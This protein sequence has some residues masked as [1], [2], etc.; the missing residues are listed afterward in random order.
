MRRLLKQIQDLQDQVNSL[1]EKEFHH[2]D[3]A[4]SS[5]VSH[6]PSQPVVVPSSREVL[7]RDSGL[8]S[9]T[10]NTTG[11]SGNV[12]ETLPARERSSSAIFKNSGTPISS[13]CGVQ[14]EKTEKRMGQVREVVREPQNSPKAVPRFQRGAG[15]FVHTRGPCSH[16]DVI[17]YPRFPV[18]EMH[19][20]KFPDC[21]EF[22]SWNVQFKTNLKVSF[23]QKHVHF[24]QRVRVHFRR[25][26]CSKKTTD[27]AVG[28]RLLTGST[29]I[30]VQP[31]H[32]KR[33]RG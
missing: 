21:M 23:A 30:F 6:L 15:V 5:G 28:G 4:S 12:F 20:G 22:Q 7:G 32:M 13:Y 17:D 10:R 8:P 2:P 31:E 25:A 16:G 29:S 14:L 1:D 18:S 24:R 3:T 33:Y 27:S 11:N 9:M 26:A 19:L